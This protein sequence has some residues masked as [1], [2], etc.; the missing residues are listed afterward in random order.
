M[1]SIYQSFLLRLA[2]DKFTYNLQLIFTTSLKSTGVVKNIAIVVR[3]DDF[4]VNVV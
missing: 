4:V 3:K 2:L 1:Q